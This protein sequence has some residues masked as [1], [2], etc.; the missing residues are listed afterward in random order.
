[1]TLTPAQTAAADS[2]KA[3]FDASPFDTDVAVSPYANRRKVRR[4]TLEALER[5]GL[6]RLEGIRTIAPH[7][8]GIH[9]ETRIIWIAA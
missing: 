9:F 1:M 3:Q 2:F 4:S 8:G 5:A 7:G 6:V